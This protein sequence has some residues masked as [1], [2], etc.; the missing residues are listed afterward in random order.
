MTRILALF[1]IAITVAAAP[2]DASGA[3]AVAAVD[4]NAGLPKIKLDVA[5]QRIS[6]EVAATPPTRE[7]G[8][9]NR[10]SIPPDE[11]MVFVFPQPQPLS[12]WMR[13]TY[14]PLSIAFIDANGRILNIADMAPRTDDTH[15]SSGVALYALEMRQGWFRRHGIDAGALVRGLPPASRE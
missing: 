2:L 13:N 11:G 6:V 10:F 15:L 9:M 1:A 7:T 14:A 5:G 4:V 8:L 3:G 12:F